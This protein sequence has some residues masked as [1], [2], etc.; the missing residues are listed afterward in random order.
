MYGGFV[1]RGRREAAHRPEERLSARAPRRR[2]SIFA[3]SRSSGVS[4][5]STSART[6]LIA[7][8]RLAASLSNVATRAYTSP[9][10][11]TEQLPPTPPRRGAASPAHAPNRRTLPR[12]RRSGATG[13]W[14]SSWNVLLLPVSSRP[15]PYTMLSW[16]RARSGRRG[17][18]RPWRLIALGATVAVVGAPAPA[19]GAVSC[20][21]AGLMPA[22][23]A[24][25]LPPTVA[26]R[27]V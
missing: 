8:S 5:D 23:R 3:P 17:L 16:L 7:S 14:A 20:A 24:S 1:V 18:M 11:W 10:L 25:R 27:T 26:L 21:F 13:G 15:V 22:V 4:P 6:M 2:M 12:S 19:L 9:P